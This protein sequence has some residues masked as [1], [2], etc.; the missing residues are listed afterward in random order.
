LT[1]REP[2]RR[3]GPPPQAK[4]DG[5][6]PEAEVIDLRERAGSTSRFERALTGQEQRQGAAPAAAADAEPRAPAAKAEPPAAP[7]DDLKRI[8]GIDTE[9]EDRLHGLGI[10]SFQQIAAL[11]AADVARIS[12][13]FGFKGRIQ[14]DNWIEQAQVLAKG[15]E[16]FYARRLARGEAAAASPIEDEGEPRNLWEVAAQLSAAAASSDARD[17]RDEAASAAAERGAPPA[18]E[19]AS[20]EEAEEQAEAVADIAEPAAGTDEAHASAEEAEEQ[21]EPVADVAEPIADAAETHASAEETEEQAEAVIDVAEPV[22][23]TDEARASAEEVAS[24]SEEP[25]EDDAVQDAA[26]ERDDLQRISAIDAEMERLLNAEGIVRYAQIADWDPADVERYSGLTGEHDRIAREN[27]IEQAQILARGGDTAYSRAYDQRMGGTAEEPEVPLHAEAIATSTA[28]D[29]SSS[30]DADRP[31]RTS[32]VAALRSVRSQALRGSDADHAA[33]REG[34]G[35]RVVRSVVPDDLKRIR[36]I[37]VLIEKR[38]NA[39]GITAYEQIANWTAADIERVSNTLDFKGRIERENWV[40]QARILASGG[41]TE[42][43]R[44][45]DRGEATLSR[46]R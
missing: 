38:L 35:V 44:R 14:T 3:A 37:G 8:R 9:L 46:P 41:Q 36:G 10:H 13:E 6:V 31:V 24:V 2:F 27:W 30:A 17:E 42:F 12:R 22:A 32:D 20:V 34:A 39:L 23:D 21:A 25:A 16:T 4:P 26:A 33:P 15:G 18:D 7:K 40:E 19:S 11:S 45:F 1:A 43:S 5:A 28:E 29:A